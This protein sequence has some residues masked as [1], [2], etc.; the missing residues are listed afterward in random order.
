MTSTKKSNPKNHKDAELEDILEE[1]EEL[2]DQEAKEKEEKSEIHRLQSLL[3]EKEEITKKAQL[4]YINLKTDFDFLVRQTQQKEQSL[5]QEILVKVVKKLLPFVEDLRKSLNNLTP[6]QKA[7]GLGKGVQM[8]YDKFIQALGDLAI[9]PIDSLHLEPDH[10]LHEPVSVVPVADK[11]LKGK[12]VEIFE[13]GFYLK[14]GD[15]KIAIIPSKV[16]IGS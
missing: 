13:Q 10:H 12:I 15:E 6:D 16:I 7:D 14:Q 9:Y 1:L 2:S 11:K 4:D 3:Q 8:I 5:N